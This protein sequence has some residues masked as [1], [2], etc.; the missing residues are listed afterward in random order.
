MI[1]SPRKVLDFPNL[2]ITSKVSTPVNEK[3]AVTTPK[4]RSKLDSPMHLSALP[5]PKRK[6]LELPGTE[7]LS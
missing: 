3:S 4:P 1:P 2:S 7:N 6:V 5:S